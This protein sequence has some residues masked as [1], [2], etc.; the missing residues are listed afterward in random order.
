MSESGPTKGLSFKQ[1]ILY[2]LIV[3]VVG[4]A[5]WYAKV[6]LDKKTEMPASTTNVVKDS[7]T[8]NNFEKNKNV[9]QNSGSGQQNN[10]SDSGTQIIKNEK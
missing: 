4:L 7:A 3:S 1:S 6:K 9:F 5:L 8:Q 2:F 10:N